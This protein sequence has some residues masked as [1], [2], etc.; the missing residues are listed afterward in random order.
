MIEDEY[1]KFQQINKKGSE[2]DFMDFLKRNDE[3][4]SI[5]KKKQ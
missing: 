4:T 5:V 1:S 3:Y 2:G